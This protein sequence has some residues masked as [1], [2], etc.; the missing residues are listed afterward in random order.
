MEE[1]RVSMEHVRA[2]RER[3]AARVR[4][5]RMLSSATA[6]RVLRA[7]GGPPIADDRVYVK[8]EHLQRTGSFKPRGTLSRLASLPAEERAA[9][10]ITL[11]AGNAAQAYAYAGA[12]EGIAVT[13]VMPL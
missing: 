8:A 9:G 7:A 2:A 12:L 13:V 11:S 4:R 10:V 5:P 6:A 1:R 3:V